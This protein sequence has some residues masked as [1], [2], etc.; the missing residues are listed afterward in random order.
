M[1]GAYNPSSGTLNPAHTRFSFGETRL[2]AVEGAGIAERTRLR[3]AGEPA[4]DLQRISHD[5]LV[6]RLPDNLIGPVLLELYNQSDRSDTDSDDRLAMEFVSET[7][8][9]ATRSVRHQE[10]LLLG[11]KHGWSLYSTAGGGLPQLWC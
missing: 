1:V 11:F 9:N 3:V 6:F 8:L 10:L 4:R 7:Q 5:R 2:V